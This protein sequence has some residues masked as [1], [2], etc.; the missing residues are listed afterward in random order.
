MRI[1]DNENFGDDNEE[2]IA[3]GA[4]GAAVN[5]VGV[6]GLWLGL[7]EGTVTICSDHF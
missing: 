1:V 5:D 3:I 2:E 7:S 4:I 6:G